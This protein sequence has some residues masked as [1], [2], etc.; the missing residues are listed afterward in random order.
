MQERAE[1]ALLAAQSAKP[2]S[3][4]TSTLVDA[5]ADPLAAWLDTQVGGADRWTWLTVDLA[6][7][8]WYSHF[9]IALTHQ[10]T[11]LVTR[12]SCSILCPSLQ[13]G[14]TLTD[15]SIFAALSRHWEADF[16]SDMAA[17]NVR[18]SSSTT[19]KSAKG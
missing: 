12:P 6:D 15:H 13:F 5:A 10:D 18:G 11:P 4:A 14:S 19:D 3:E 1:A 9:K 2:S 17:L 16:H 7:S 8:A